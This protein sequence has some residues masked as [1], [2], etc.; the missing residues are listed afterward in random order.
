MAQNSDFMVLNISSI[1]EK[2]RT[3]LVE[4]ISV[5]RG[6]EKPYRVIKVQYKEGIIGAV[7][8]PQLDWNGRL[9]VRNGYA[10]HDYEYAIVENAKPYEIVVYGSKVGEAVLPITTPMDKRGFK[11]D[12]ALLLNLK[13]REII[14]NITK[15]K[16][17]YMIDNKMWSK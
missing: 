8:I 15:E 2:A 12:D 13:T 14:C 4:T 16:N 10:C 3:M 9:T 11:D 5:D 6:V 7:C 1:D 17:R